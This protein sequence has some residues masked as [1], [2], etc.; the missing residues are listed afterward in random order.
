MS[1]NTV[2]H[3]RETKEAGLFVEQLKA[4]SA[5]SG[6]FDSAAAGDFISGAVNQ[7]AAKIPKKLQVLLDEVGQD[8]G[9]VVAQAILDGVNA[10]EKAHGIEAPADVIE[11]AIHSGYST[12]DEAKRAMALDSAS[13]S[14]HADNLSLQPNRA[15]V[16]ILSALG[17]A[18]PFG[19]YLPADISS[20]EAVLAILSH[21]AGNT[22]GQ[23]AE[24]GLM[25]G[26]LSGD[27]Y[28]TSARIHATTNSSG[29]HSG[30]LTSVQSDEDTC[31][32]V[33][34]NGAVA[35]KL[36]RGRSVVYVKGIPC[37]REIDKTGSGNS[38]VSGSITISG[39]TYQIGGT[40]NTDTGAIAVTSTP[41]LDDAVPVIVEG[42]IDYERMPGLT[43]SIITAVNTFSLFA[44]PWRVIT[45]QTIDSSTQMQNELGLDPYSE[46]IIAIQAQF[47]NERHYEALRKGLRLAI[48]NALTHDFDWD[49]QG[50]QK[51][52]AQIWQDV[53]APLGVLS[54][55]MAVNT[56]SHGITHLYV[57]K[58]IASMLLSLPTDLF[59]PSGIKVR[60]GIFRLGRLFGMYEVYYTPKV[61]SDTNSSAQI[62]CVGRAN[63]VTRNPIVLGDAVTPT[64]LPLAM[65]ADLKRGAGFYARNF[66]EVNPHEP[67]SL[68]FAVL[69]LTG[70]GL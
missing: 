18:I 64:V 67:S 65:N 16:A 17:E 30:Q 15:V 22:Y 6:T 35:V 23:Y 59:V 39:T 38:T 2:I 14:N 60:P 20:N 66:T 32:A 58:Y 46:S 37:A 33:G 10:Y 1:K 11:M 49:G 42:F 4:N 28:I 5:P 48:N 68:G 47:G 3:K 8:N 40:I 13:S 34:V 12:T 54:Q 52:R 36:L 43:P 56:L 63:D 45:Q 9:V 26:T 51:T 53:A 25:D 61:V 29:A 19:H 27:A 55:A 44:K 31:A 70:M 62:L 21:K 24:D 57:G 69:T 7:N 41:A 50:L